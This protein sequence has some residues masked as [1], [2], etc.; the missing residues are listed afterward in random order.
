LASLLVERARLLEEDPSLL[1]VVRLGIELTVR[2]GP[3][4]EYGTFAELPLD[5]LA[6]IVRDGQDSGDIRAGLD[7]RATAET[8][9]AGILGIDQAALMLSRTFDVSAR[10]ERLLDVVIPGLQAKRRLAPKQARKELP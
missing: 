7:P 6:A 9:F 2:Y 5:L 3:D 10:T 8:I 1:V 4:S